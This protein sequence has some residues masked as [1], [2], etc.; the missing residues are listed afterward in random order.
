M[1]PCKHAARPSGYRMLLLF[2]MALGRMLAVPPLVF[3]RPL[4]QRG[5]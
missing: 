4:A 5:L 3:E 2:V 1:R